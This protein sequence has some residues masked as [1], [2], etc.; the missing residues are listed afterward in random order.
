MKR[1]AWILATL[2]SCASC[3]ALR[4]PGASVLPPPS[5]D[6]LTLHLGRRALSDDAYEPVDEQGAI[7]VE[8]VHGVPHATFAWEVGI[9]A[10]RSEETAAGVEVEGKTL[11]AYSGLHRAFGLGRVRPYLGAGLALVRTEIEAAGAGSDDGGSAAL[12]AHGGVDVRLSQSFFVGVDLRWLFGSSIQYAAF[13][14]D[15]DYA[16]VALRLGWEL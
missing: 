2:A 1:C 10:S 7:G 12:Y 5:Q 4:A 9:A 13:R 15:G 8:L 3:A 11:E 14:T 16:Q 6:S